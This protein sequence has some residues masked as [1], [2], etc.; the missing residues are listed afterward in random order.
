VL[1]SLEP[2]DSAALVERANELLRRVHIDFHPKL[3]SDADLRGA[4]AVLAALPVLYRGLAWY[5]GLR[6]IYIVPGYYETETSYVDEAGVVHEG[7]EEAS[8]EM[9]EQGP[10][11]LSA[12]DIASSGQGSG[13]NVV[14]H[15][16]AHI[17]D[18]TSGELDGVPVLPDEVDPTRWR[19]AFED[20]YAEH[21]RRVRR[22]GARREAHRP[23]G[24]RPVGVRPVGVRA[25]GPRIQRP[26]VDPYG[27]EN[28]A[29][30][31]ACAAELFFERPGRL[32]R[33]HPEL[34]RQMRA[35]YGFS[36]GRGLGDSASC[37]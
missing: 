4:V 32:E 13:Y 7:R 31:F 9:A 22:G 17:I 37:I 25:H 18:L 15:E 30:F 5:A 26:V 6:S 29:E 35:L 12:P 34:W 14:I 36:P 11:V 27:T 28:R 2:G 16:M 19:R 1:A 20:A 3:E 33:G 21:C 10:V 8:G 24:V 23:V